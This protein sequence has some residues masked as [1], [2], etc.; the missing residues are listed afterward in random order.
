MPD[1]LPEY[2]ALVKDICSLG[3]QTHSVISF[4]DL[5]KNNKKKAD[6]K[7]FISRHDIDTDLKTA[8]HIYD[9]ERKYGVRSSFYFRISTL[10]YKFMKD[11]DQFGSEASYHFEEIASYCKKYRITTRENAN[12]EIRKIQELLCSNFSQIKKESGLEMRSIASHGD[13]VNRALK[14]NNY[15]LIDDRLRDKLKIELECY[16]ISYMSNFTARISDKPAPLYYYPE[17][18]MRCIERNE[19]VI[20]FL[21]HP[22]QWHSSCY[23]N[24]LEIAKRSFEGLRYSMKI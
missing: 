17:P 15:E 2:E 18:I 11:I 22:R 5:L 7:Y 23:A 3:Y 14:M 1:R 10:D 12:R 16:D 13:F 9:I 8:R 4:Y 24:T 20:Y 6:E 21:S 19:P